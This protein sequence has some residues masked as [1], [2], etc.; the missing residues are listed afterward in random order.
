MTLTWP[1]R[2][3]LVCPPPLDDACN[4]RPTKHLRPSAESASRCVVMRNG[5]VISDAAIRTWT[6]VHA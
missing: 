5:P 2:L 4:F 1:A 6:M 3:Q